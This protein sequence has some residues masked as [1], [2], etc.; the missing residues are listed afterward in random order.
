[1]PFWSAF[2]T[3]GLSLW[4]NAM[5]STHDLFFYVRVRS[6]KQWNKM[7]LLTRIFI[8]GTFLL[9]ILHLLHFVPMGAVVAQ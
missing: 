1:M 7:L 9:A 8:G 6:C 4:Q 3:K 5:I 2:L